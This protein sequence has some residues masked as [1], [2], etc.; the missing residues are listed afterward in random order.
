MLSKSFE[1]KSN[2]TIEFSKVGEV[3]H[4]RLFDPLGN[5]WY[6]GDDIKECASSLLARLNF[7]KKITRQSTVSSEE[8]AGAL[9]WF[10]NMFK[11]EMYKS[12]E[13]ILLLF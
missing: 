9:A 2:L 6:E 12:E 11:Q 13:A 1:L 4:M 3:Y 5:L 8:N 7:I 10:F